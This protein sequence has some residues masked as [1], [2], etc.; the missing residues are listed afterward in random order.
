MDRK[1]EVLLHG[2]VYTIECG[3]TGKPERMLPL[4]ALG[5]ELL[6]YIEDDDG[7]FIYAYKPTGTTT[8]GI[9]KTIKSLKE[10]GYPR[11][12]E[13]FKE[14]NY[15]DEHTGEILRTLYDIDLYD[16]IEAIGEIIEQ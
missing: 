8:K 1:C 3:S 7:K 16:I 9:Y 6:D 13:K 4:E 2:T 5:D 11:I 14:V 12:V 10:H 15:I